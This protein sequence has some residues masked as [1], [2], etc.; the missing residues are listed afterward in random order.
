MKFIRILWGDFNRYESQIIEAKNDELNE[1]VFVWGKDNLEKLTNLGYECVLIDEEPY[2]Y[3][4]ADNHTFINHKSLI[5]KIMGIGLA[6]K[7]FDEVIFVDWDC[8]KIKEI[9]DRFFELIKSRNSELQVP[10]YT[11]PIFAFDMLMNDVKEDN[12]ITFF[13]KLKLFITNYSFK[14]SNSY[15]IPN[16]G[17][18]YCSNKEIIADLLKLI[19]SNNLETIPDE[20]SVF[21]YTNSLGLDG[22]IDKIEPLVVDG[23]EHG[24]SWWNNMEMVFSEYKKKRITKEIYFKHL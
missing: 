4:I 15:V 7:Q 10:L 23:K 2:D 3:T 6:L 1:T 21:L 24:Y 9:D 12:M 18:F 17:F 20:L 22:Y 19:I 8:R 13:T 16:T 11:Y 5:H 14:Y